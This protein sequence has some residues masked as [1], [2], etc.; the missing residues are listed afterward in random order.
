MKTLSNL[1]VAGALTLILGSNLGTASAQQTPAETPRIDTHAIGGV[2]TG[3]QGPEAGVW[4]IA[5]TSGL[6][7]KFAK[8]V[9][10]D[11]RGRYVIPDLPAA[12]YDVWVRGYGLV[13]SPKL[14]SAPGKIVDLKATPAPDA[15]AAAQY[16]P[17]LYWYALLQVPPA[18]DFPGTGATGNGMPETLK[19]QG[20]WLDI[21]KT[22][23]CF[24][25]HQLGNAATRAIEP[26]L[27]EFANSAEAWEARIQSGQA[28]NN[29]VN[30][31]GR[32][33]TQRALKL[34]ADWTDRIAAGAV[35][36]A[37]P[38]R[39]QGVER[40]L[41]VT[42]W[43]WSDAKAYLHDSISTD[44]RDPTVNPNGLLYGATEEST[45]DLPVL[46]PVKNI[47]TTIHIPV[48]DPNT[49]SAKDL[50]VL[51]A[52]SYWGEDKIWDSQAS[53]HNPMLD[54]EGRVWFTARIRGEDNPAFCKKGSDHP[55]AKAFPVEKSTRQLAMYDPKT[56]KFT[57]IDT[58][59]STH[60]LQFAADADNMLWTSAGGPQSPVAGWLNTKKFLATGDAAASQG[61]TA[62]V[63]D[64]NAN[65]KRDDY[66]E[67]NQPVDPQKDE[68][69]VAGLYGVA[70]SPTDGTIWGTTLGFPGGVVHL[71]PGAN[72][73]ETALTEFYQ[74][75]WDDPKAQV[76]GYSPR[77]MD[78]DKQGV[79]WMPL[80]SG[81]FA[82][83][84]RKKCEGPLNGPQAI[85]RQCP[86]GWTLYPFPGPKLEN[87][88]GTGSAEASYYAWVDQFNTLGLGAD[89]PI[90]TGN[91]AEGLLALVDGKFVT[92]RVPYPLGFYI[93]GMDGRIDDPGAGWKGRGIW[94]TTGS[95][96][97]FHMEGGK[98]TR[99]KVYHFQLRP[100]P[101]AF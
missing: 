52:S 23:G 43:D 26:Q 19:S 64:T 9:V 6:P 12:T 54:K 90:A 62:F 49:P 67:P 86:E 81:H 28:A 40:N 73:P 51:R 16:Y 39:P 4:V 35:P 71:I 53:V 98:G 17:A 32:L 82:S 21:V 13:D 27:G 75:P 29:M 47:A 66:V 63:L 94:T 37:A 8:I 2:V 97:P 57:L 99:P 5:E 72:P 11:E 80:A 31:I 33:D 60:H 1:G 77:G 30:N 84:D 3:A 38:Q 93:K 42:L 65:G 68:R 96:T 74:P 91:G 56:Q 25:C 55:S 70:V 58:C 46:D 14:Q 101:L 87:D 76:H 18:G 95:R 41:V 20:Q 34:F 10:T 100:D 78:I 44:R 79:V 88:A 7:T 92:L 59:F 85:G 61:W 83:F 45:Q 24:T 22:D 50:P 48:R 36:T 89:V 15:K 69:I